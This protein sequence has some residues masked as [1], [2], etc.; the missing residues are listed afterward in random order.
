MVD[1]ISTYVIPCAYLYSYCIVKNIFS[2]SFILFTLFIGPKILVG[3]YLQSPL[4][5]DKETETQRG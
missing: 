4:V 1:E 2:F 3:R 5:L